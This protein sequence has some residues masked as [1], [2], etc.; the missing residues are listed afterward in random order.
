MER[1]LVISDKVFTMKDLLE[2]SEENDGEIALPTLR[3]YLHIKVEEKYIG[4]QLNKYQK[5]G[6]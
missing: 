1:H 6:Q 4:K 5:L 2:W 3:E